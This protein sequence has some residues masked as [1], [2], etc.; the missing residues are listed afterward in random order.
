MPP[1]R[2]LLLVLFAEDSCRQNHALMY[3][4][5]LHDKGHAVKLI[6]EGAATKLV[7]TVQSAESRTGALLRQALDAGV[8]AGACGRASS[9]CASEDPT[10]K[11]ADLAQAAGV[12]LLADLHGHA[13]IEPFVREGYEIVVI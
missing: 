2:K 7:G 10:R 1:S 12:P 13:S 5:D 11:V 9:G 8:L 3:A 4:L 6:L